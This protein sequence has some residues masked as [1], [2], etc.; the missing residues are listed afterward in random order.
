MHGQKPNE[1]AYF[2]NAQ[3]SFV[4]LRYLSK[5]RLIEHRVLLGVLQELHFMG[6]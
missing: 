3:P 2:F 4:N 6:G 5:S 1:L